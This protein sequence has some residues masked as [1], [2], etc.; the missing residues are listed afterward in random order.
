MWTGFSIDLLD[1][2]IDFLNI[3]LTYSLYLNPDNGFIGNYVYGSGW[4]GSF[5]ELVGQRADVGIGPLGISYERAKAV[6][7]SYPFQ[8]VSLALVTRAP[9]T[10]G[11]N[12]WRFVE[13][14][15]LSVWLLLGGLLIFL[16]FV[17]WIYEAI[18]PFGFSK[19]LD[20]VTRHNYGLGTS[21]ARSM[22]VIM[23]LGETRD[24]GRAWS[25]RLLMMSNFFFALI[26]GATYTASLTEILLTGGQAM[27]EITSINDVRNGRIPFGVV[28]A[29]A[30]KDFIQDS[31]DHSYSVLG[32]LTVVYKVLFLIPFLFPYSI[33]SSS[34]SRLPHPRPC[35]RPCPRP[36]SLGLQPNDCGRELGRAAGRGTFLRGPQILHQSGITPAAN[37]PLFV[38]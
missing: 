4:T 13:P 28:D 38:V 26:V 35:P 27:S 10:T 3:S 31:P 20:R 19:S 36:L 33:F 22:L 37:I 7:F 23:M 9:A 12:W 17:A 24:F 18:S 5:G 8:D 29:E 1:A 21:L 6:D 30:P 25:T 15:S 16:A 11:S 32:K 2:V 14:F 34:R